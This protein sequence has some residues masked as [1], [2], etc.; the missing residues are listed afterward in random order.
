MTK[1]KSHVCVRLSKSI[2]TLIG[3]QNFC[4]KYIQISNRLDIRPSHFAFMGVAK[5]DYTSGIVLLWA[6]IEAILE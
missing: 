6:S 3:L 2:N 1:V 5:R 4:S